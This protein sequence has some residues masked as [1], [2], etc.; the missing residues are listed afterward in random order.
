MQVPIH[1]IWMWAPRFCDSNKLPDNA[2]AA[3]PL[4]TLGIARV[5]DKRD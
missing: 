1:S 3:G 5:K 2:I 4:S